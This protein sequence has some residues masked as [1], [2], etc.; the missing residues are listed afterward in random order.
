MKAV[1]LLFG[2][3]THYIAFTGMAMLAINDTFGGATELLEK[4]EPNTPEAL[5]A[6]S[7][8]I[9]ILAEQGELARRALNYTPERI[10]ESK[11]FLSCAAPTDIVKM[12][13]AVPQAITLGFG[14][15]IVDEQ[16]EVDLV[17][18]ELNQKKTN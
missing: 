6:L 2:G 10:F 5:T 1:K 9:A 12:K 3:K 11:E 14:R 8:A 17:L 15:E 7:A 18:A 4:I 13:Q 16:E